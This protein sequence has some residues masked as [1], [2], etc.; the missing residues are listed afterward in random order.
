MYSESN[1]KTR[2]EDK[3][4]EENTVEVVVHQRP[5]EVPYKAAKKYSAAGFSVIPICLDGSKSPSDRWKKYESIPA[6]PVELDRWFGGRKQG[7]GIVC[8]K[9]SGSLEVI[10]FDKKSLFDEWREL[11]SSEE[12]EIVDDLPAVLTPRPGVHLYYRCDHVE[13][14]QKLAVS[15]SEETLIETRGEG[16]YVV[17][18]GSPASCH[19]TH[20]PY[21]HL[22]GP[23]LTEVPMIDSKTRATF[24][25]AARELTE[26]EVIAPKRPFSQ[27]KVSDEQRPGD[28]FNETEDWSDILELH[29]WRL[30]RTIGA[31]TQWLRPGKFGQGCSATTGY[32]DGDCLYI[33][34]SNAHPFEPN[35]A[36]SKFAAYALL[37]HGGDFRRAAQQLST[38]G[39]GVDV[40][41]ELAARAMFSEK[42]VSSSVTDD[43]LVLSASDPL[44]AAKLYYD[45]E[46]LH[47]GE[48]RLHHHRSTWKEWEGQC[49]QEAADDD[50][51][52]QIWGWLSKHQQWLKEKD[53]WK[54]VPYEPNT[55][56]VSNVLDAL[57][58]V[59]NLSSTREMPSWLGAGD[60]PNPENII[61]FQNGLLDINEYLDAGSTELIEHSPVWFS[62]NCLPH[63]FDAEATCPR[64]S[65]FLNEVLDGN[66]ESIDTLAQWFG[67]CMTSDTR[68]QK[69]MMLVGPPRSGKGTTT[70]I[71]SALLG[72]HNVSNP[73]FSSLGERFG[74]EKLVG[75]LVAIISDGHLGRRS[76]TT[77]ILERLKSII[78]GDPQ[79][80]DR[81]NRKE[82]SNVRLPVRFTIVVNEMPR[83]PDASAALR[84]RL[85]LIPFRKSFEGKEKLDLQETL[86]EEIPGI[87]NW[88]LSGLRQLRAKGRLLQP[89]TGKKIVRDFARLSSPVLAFIEDCCE[90]GTDRQV[91]I[92]DLRLAWEHWCDH[93]GHECGS[94]SVF[95]EKLRAVHPYIDRFRQGRDNNGKQTYF[96]SNIRLNKESEKELENRKT[97]YGL[98]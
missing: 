14:N 78:G 51:R 52:S 50:V 84:S 15:S 72:T 61:S 71:L 98:N 59:A 34:S 12:L 13:G 5:W 42:S 81:K 10:D 27:K 86:I 69:L 21:T 30:A 41:A 97:Q 70:S 94:K 65:K 11:L 96:Y 68:Q 3:V 8:G 44:G 63:S 25:A 80:V 54:L 6:T 37:N 55:N 20:R 77:M 67:Y 89:D 19:P 22:A 17:A 95:G 53:K 64:W 39:Y 60:Y 57:R 36:Y 24:L 31:V 47:G 74:L 40:S 33:F 75:K 38:E 73:M 83:M 58:S 26:V 2:N 35:R 88:A 62:P 43:N 90:I 1:S 9:V 79:D 66:I 82:E 76:N 29:D 45:H 16:G 56:R 28:V 92:S 93:N 46:C 85:L 49:Y 23:D 7:V 48:G 32:G 91:K 18:P 4:S 87:T